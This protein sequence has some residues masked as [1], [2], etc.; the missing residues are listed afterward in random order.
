MTVRTGVTEWITHPASL[1][2]NIFLKSSS[3]GVCL[4]CEV[5]Q[6]RLKL[7]QQPTSAPILGTEMSHWL[8][9]NWH[10]ENMIYD[11]TRRSDRSVVLVTSPRPRLDKVVLHEAVS[12]A[13]QEIWLDICICYFCTSSTFSH[14]SHPVRLPASKF[15]R[16]SCS[17]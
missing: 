9:S 2:R 5:Q 10:W 14:L 11:P 15:W 13:I 12:T 6:G 16:R 17:S 1:T 7:E 4:Q 3:S 8:L